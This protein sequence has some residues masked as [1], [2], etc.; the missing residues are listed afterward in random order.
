MIDLIIADVYHDEDEYDSCTSIIFALIACYI[1]LCYEL[2][3]TLQACYLY[4]IF[5]MRKRGNRLSDD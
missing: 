4:G 1:R 3:F 5:Q 2:S